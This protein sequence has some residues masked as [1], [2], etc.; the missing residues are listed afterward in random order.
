VRR[1]FPLYAFVGEEKWDSFPLRWEMSF[2]FAC[3][4]R[5]KSH[6]SSTSLPRH[7]PFDAVGQGGLDM[8]INANRIK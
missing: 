1:N 5:S 8:P 3:L 4:G 6:P 7:A 2:P